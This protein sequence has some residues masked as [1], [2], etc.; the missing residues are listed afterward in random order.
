[1]P[2]LVPMKSRTL[3][4]AAIVGGFTMISRVLGFV[5]DLLLAHALGAGAV[6]DAFFVA[7]KLPNFFRRMLAEGTLA[8][9]VIPVLADAR[10]EGEEATWRY[11]NLVLVV[12]I[13]VLLALTLAGELGMKALLALFAPG[14]VHD[15]ARWNT[16]LAL[17]HITFP[18]LFFI[19]LAAF[20]WAVQNAF[21][22]FALAA[23]SPALLN[24]ALIFAAVVL[25]PVLGDAGRALAWGVI[26]GG[27][28]QLGA[29]IPALVRL[30]WRVARGLLQELARLRETLRLFFPAFV[31]VAAVQ[32]HVLVGTILA[33]LLPQGAVSA[34][35]YADRLVQLPLAL[36][37][38]AMGTALL[39]TLSELYR[40][41]NDEAAHAELARGITGLSWITLPAALGLIVLADPI[42]QVLFV[43][44][45]FTEAD[46]ARTAAAL[47][48]YALGLV[49]FS[50]TKALAAACYARKDAK[51]PMR[52]TLFSLAI[53]LA[54]AVAL[55]RP[56][57]AAGLALAT[58]AAGWANA[59]LLFRRAQGKQ[60]LLA[61]PHARRIARAL[62]A[63]LG[64]LALLKLALHLWPAPEG[65]AMQALRLLALVATG[66]ASFALLARVMG[67]RIRFAKEPRDARSAAK[68]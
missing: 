24:L 58:S 13:F 15:P 9:A 20:F 27:I 39:P 67:E 32:L 44:G 22:R 16:A 60:A 1:M 61:A 4:A 38:I 59:L 6:A 37:G 55:M 2:M 5:R 30:G 36:F 49:A 43:H 68:T 52:Y 19:T 7:F 14:F 11:L 57:G 65:W 17:A 35:Y 53:N 12:L 10:K 40:D 42:V 45:R 23:A 34:L 46:A 50:W 56:L 48:A 18:Y 66:A 54:A 41:G 51:A 26:A 8:S 31:S 3:R 64:M 62:A 47:V 29:Q 33:S 63:A 28:L 21:Q 25:A